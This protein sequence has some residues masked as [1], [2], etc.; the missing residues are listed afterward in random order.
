MKN[1]N[2]GPWSTSYTIVNVRFGLPSS[3]RTVL[4]TAVVCA[5]DRQSRKPETS[6]GR[7]QEGEELT[8]NTL[9]ARQTDSL[10]RTEPLYAYS[11]FLPFKLATGKK[12]DGMTTMV[13]SLVQNGRQKQKRVSVVFRD[14]NA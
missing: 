13:Y 5:T 6:S 12:R 14:W 2:W 11:C 10:R 1:H 7:V 4:L 3:T 9:K 8:T